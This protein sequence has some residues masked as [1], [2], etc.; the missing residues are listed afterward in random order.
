MD[1]LSGLDNRIDVIARDEIIQT[2][3]EEHGSA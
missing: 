1:L 2:W 3:K